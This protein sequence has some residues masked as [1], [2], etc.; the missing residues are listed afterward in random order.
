[1]SKLN[2]WF[3]AKRESNGGGAPPHQDP[4]PPR[5]AGPMGPPTHESRSQWHFA[6]RVVLSLALLGLGI[7]ILQNYLRALVWALVLAIALWPLY[8]RAAARVPAKLRKEV[9]PAIVSLA[10]LLIVLIPIVLLGYEAVRE[11][12]VVVD[13]GKQAEQ[14]GI[15]VPDAVGKLPPKI[16][17]PVSKWWTENL[18][19]SGVAKEWTQKLDTATNREKGRDLGKEALH[20]IIL[21]GFALL[22]LFF[23]CSEGEAVNRQCLTASYRLFGPRGERIGRQMV[24]SIHGTVNG[25]VLVG[26]GEGV[27]LGVVYFFTGVPHP[28]LIGAVSAVAAMVPF[29]AGVAIMVAA[30]LLLAAGKTAM[31]VVVVVAGFLV[32]F[33]ADHFVRPKLIGGA[34]KL[35]FLWV[36]LGILG[37]VETFGLLGLFLGPAIMAALILLWR[38]LSGEAA[39]A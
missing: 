38:E 26:L 8:V 32:T 9:L 7:Y 34:T 36:L 17:A 33:I 6:A 24:A 30:L 16:A 23:L 22:A 25:L 19:H 14:N 15:P 31:A 28:I 3:G 37:G 20:R 21:F 12:H 39:D 1:M 10:I 11:A 27:V 5:P 2:E 18:S 4:K 35:P 29:A 13:Y